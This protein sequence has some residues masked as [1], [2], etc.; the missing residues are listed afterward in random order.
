MYGHVV[1]ELERTGTQV[2]EEMY[3]RVSR[4]LLHLLTDRK[5]TAA[6]LIPIFHPWESGCDDSARWDSWRTSDAVQ[7]ASQPASDSMSDSVSGSANE[8]RIGSVDAWRRHKGELVRSLVVDPKG[9][10]T[11]SSLFSVGSVGFNALVAWN[12]DELLGVAQRRTH[13]FGSDVVRQLTELEVRTAELKK[14]IRQRWDPELLTWHDDG[15]ASGRIRTADA[16][17]A[18]LVDPRPEAF[19]S[20]ADSEAFAG[21]FGIR[22]AHKAE[23][24]YDPAT[25][26]R[27]PS[28][29]QIIYLLNQAARPH[30][31]Q[32]ASTISERF[33]AGAIKSG[34]AEYWHPET[35]QGLGAIPQTWTGLAVL[36]QSQPRH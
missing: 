1:A 36:A 31:A 25:Y 2:E 14:A 19:E 12:S 5:R 13:S 8:E 27:G 3:S 35:G 34:L 29:P 7:I 21:P 28:W 9:G 6:S 16:L 26:W 20:L 17:L 32:L 30:S 24:A 4:G 10:P 22:G 15:P 18:L 11:G 23:P 33:V